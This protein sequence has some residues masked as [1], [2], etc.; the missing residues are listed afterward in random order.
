MGE[1]RKK[2]PQEFESYFSKALNEAME[3]YAREQMG[4]EAFERDINTESK[5]GELSTLEAIAADWDACADWLLDFFK[6]TIN[7]EIINEYDKE[8]YKNVKPRTSG[9]IGERTGNTSGI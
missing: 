9:T 1:Y 4:N 5:E 8:D 2:F 6:I 3:K 7:M